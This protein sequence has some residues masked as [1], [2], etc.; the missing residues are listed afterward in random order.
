MSDKRKYE[1]TQPINFNNKAYA[2]GKTVDLDDDDA[3]PLLAA[4]AVKLPDTEKKK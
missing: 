2:P 1:V 3:G 4:N